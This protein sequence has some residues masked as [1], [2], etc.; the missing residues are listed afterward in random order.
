MGPYW[1]RGL[2]LIEIEDPWGILKVCGVLWAEQPWTFP[3]RSYLHPQQSALLKDGET[4]G[5]TQPRKQRTRTRT[6]I[7]RQEPADQLLSAYPISGSP[8]STM[9]VVE[10][11]LW[12]SHGSHEGNLCSWEDSGNAKGQQPTGPPWMV[13]HESNR[14]FS[15][16]SSWYSCYC[17]NVLIGHPK[18]GMCHFS[19][20]INLPN[21][22]CSLAFA[23][24]FFTAKPLSLDQQH[25]EMDVLPFF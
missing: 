23:Y 19:K 17:I 6:D 20:S 21:A 1:T 16:F 7:W 22:L 15:S 14:G 11:A 9:F 25:S 10:E 8:E 4:A 2:S 12:S 13:H 18:A 3:H 5:L 24:V